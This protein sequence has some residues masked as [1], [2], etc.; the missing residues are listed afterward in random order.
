ML[1]NLTSFV[2]V[3]LKEGET[4]ESLA[5]QAPAVAPEEPAI[6]EGDISDGG[7][8]GD[9]S[10]GGDSG[11]S[12]DGGDDGNVDAFVDLDEDESEG[13]MD[14]DEDD[15][16][17]FGGA[18]PGMAMERSAMIDDD[19]L[20]QLVNKSECLAE[21]SAQ[22]QAAPRPQSSGL[23]SKLSSV[24]S[25]K[26][27]SAPPPPPAPKALAPC[28][29]ASSMAAPCAPPPALSVSRSSAAMPQK[30]MMLD[31]AEE[32]Q[33]PQ[34]EMRKKASSRSVRPETLGAASS[35]PAPR[36]SLESIIVAQSADGSWSWS[37][38]LQSV[39]SGTA[40]KSAADILNAV[41]EFTQSQTAAITAFVI[42]VLR[43]Q[44]QSESSKWKLIEAK[45]LAFVQSAIGADDDFDRVEDLIAACK[46]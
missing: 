8:D 43:S 30:R 16:P 10:D 9:S 36:V 22:F 23:F 45:A 35:S 13:A 31:E 25:R 3:D 21:S 7:D 19:R 46:L 2:A 37:S 40:L 1:T 28:V 4:I 15:A 44:F 24:F 14:D 18:P 26:E 20:D 12:S 42:A 17:S 41:S 6:D 27:S 32:E 33:R 34:M 39:A 38:V 11:D 5:A 29:A